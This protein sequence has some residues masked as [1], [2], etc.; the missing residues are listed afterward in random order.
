MGARPEKGRVQIPRLGLLK[1]GQA[2]KEKRVKKDKGDG[3]GVFKSLG[4]MFKGKKKK[5]AEAAAP[6]DAA[7]TPRY[8]SQCVICFVKQLKW[9]I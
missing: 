8:C 5:A 9:G 3:K 2:K 4:G 6:T 1:K 7:P